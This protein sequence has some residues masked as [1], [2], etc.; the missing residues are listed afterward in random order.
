MYILTLYSKFSIKFAESKT[1]EERIIKKCI[2]EI[3]VNSFRNL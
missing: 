2:V 1:R 3:Y